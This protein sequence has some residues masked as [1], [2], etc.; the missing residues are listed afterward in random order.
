M[1][2]PNIQAR[3]RLDLAINVLQMLMDTNQCVQGCRTPRDCRCVI[4][5]DELML[6][7]DDLLKDHIERIRAH[8]TNE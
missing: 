4:Q 2:K 6:E 1:D 8:K 3:L 5:A 7:L